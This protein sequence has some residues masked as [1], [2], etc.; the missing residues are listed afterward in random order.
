VTHGLSIRQS[1]VLH[2]EDIR[3]AFDTSKN[4]LRPGI[5]IGFRLAEWHNLGAPDCFCYPLG[6]QYRDVSEAMMEDDD[7]YLVA[8]VANI[9][10]EPGDFY[11]FLANLEKTMKLSLKQISF[12]D[13]SPIKDSLSIP[14]EYLLKRDLYQSRDPDRYYLDNI[15]HYNH[16]LRYCTFQNNIFTPTAA[17][18][19]H[20]SQDLSSK[21][22]SWIWIW[23]DRL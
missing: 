18:P 16:L 4:F 5:S 22:S 14:D 15:P 2:I 8:H 6:H 12:L 7:H 11:V 23:P 9:C 17:G 21:L 20:S 10:A 19:S 13:G 3:T 1:L